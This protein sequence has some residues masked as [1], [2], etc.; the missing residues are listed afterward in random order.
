MV[1]EGQKGKLKPYV[2]DKPIN[3][4]G[5][6]CFTTVGT[7]INNAAIPETVHDEIKDDWI[8]HPEKL[9]RGNSTNHL[10]QQQKIPP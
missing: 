1:P 9:H 4:R 10:Y 8:N 7:Q 5:R 2:A 6:G 3:L